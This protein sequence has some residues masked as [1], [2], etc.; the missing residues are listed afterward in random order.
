MAL[1]FKGNVRLMFYGSSGTG[2]SC[3]CAE[4]IEKRALMFE[5]EPK[6]ILWY[7]KHIESV[8]KTIKSQVEVITEYPNLESFENPTRVH[9]LIVLDDLQEFISQST[10]VSEAFRSSRH[11]NISIIILVH[12]LFSGKKETRNI[13]LNCSGI[14]IMKSCRD[15]VPLR[16]LS[17]QLTPNSPDKLLAIY[18]FHV[19]KAYQYIFVDLTIETNDLIRY[20][21]D[22]FS[23]IA[24]QIFVD[25]HQLNQLKKNE[26]KL[27]E[28][29]QIHAFV[30][31]I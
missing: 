13:S 26:Q 14:F 9:K 6:R 29:S 3:L 17:M 27:G 25:Q 2:K 7:C 30:L 31:G 10:V 1:K 16:N 19:K 12:N 23:L 24:L 15:L 21:T 5:N 20:R 28:N 22:I 8:P 18:D 11:I 4:L